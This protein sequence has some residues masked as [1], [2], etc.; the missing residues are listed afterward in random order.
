[1]VTQTSVHA[2]PPLPIWNHHAASPQ[3]FLLSEQKLGLTVQQ[4]MRGTAI[5]S[6]RVPATPAMNAIQRNPQAASL[7]E[8]D[9]S[10]KRP[11]TRSNS[12]LSACPNWA[13]GR[14]RR[15]FQAA[16]YKGVAGE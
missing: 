15:P 3:C 6:C 7:R 14:R 8:E 16:P 1:A 10:R 11:S 4:K 2:P 13:E 5:R 9:T 12:H